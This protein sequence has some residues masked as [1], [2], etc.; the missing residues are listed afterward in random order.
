[1]PRQRVS[2]GTVGKSLHYSVFLL[3]SRVCEEEARTRQGGTCLPLSLIVVFDSE[4]RIDTSLV[5]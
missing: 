4:T 5:S 2:N 3:L 1:M